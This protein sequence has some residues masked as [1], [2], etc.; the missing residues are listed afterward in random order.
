MGKRSKNAKSLSFC[1]RICLIIFLVLYFTVTI[2]GQQ[3]EINNLNYQI[4]D[5]NEKIEAKNNELSIIEDKTK[6]AT[7]D[8]T[9]ESIARER[10][11]L[12]RSN[13]TVFVDITG[14]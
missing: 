8:E 4:S 7:S 6:N 2:I 3:S 12:V 10:L 1:L 9:V 5:Y 13:E 14:K 11:G